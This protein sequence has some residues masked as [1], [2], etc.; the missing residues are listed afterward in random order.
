MRLI[1]S[2]KFID[3]R[4]L[5]QN[6]R[7][8]AKVC[9]DI[10]FV[11]VVDNQS[12]RK[13]GEIRMDKTRYSFDLDPVLNP[14]SDADLDLNV[15]LDPN[16]NLNFGLNLYPKSRFRTRYKYDGHLEKIV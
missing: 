7:R 2:P 11:F 9:F 10:T 8:L 15:N 3:C 1:S 4:Q 6:Y 5:Q 16:N 12:G 13:F 14:N